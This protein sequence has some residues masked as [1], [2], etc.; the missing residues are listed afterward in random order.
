VDI[1]AS[2]QRLAALH[3]EY[4][5]MIMVWAERGEEMAAGQFDLAVGV[6]RDLKAAGIRCYA[7]SNMEPQAFTIRLTRFPFMTWFDGHVISGKEAW[8]SPIS[9]SSKS[10]WNAT[11]WPPRR[12]SSQMTRYVTSRPPAHSGS[13][14]C[15]TP[16]LSNSGRNSRHLAFQGPRDAGLPGTQAQQ[17]AQFKKAGSYAPEIDLIATLSLS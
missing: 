8:P 3:P 6:L 16:A 1:T 11:A 17:A 2:C 10:S 14:P 13:M 9:G 15:I 5:D 4:R 7:L 12:S